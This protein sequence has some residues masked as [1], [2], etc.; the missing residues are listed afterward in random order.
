MSEPSPFLAVSPQPS[1]PAE[2][3]GPMQQLGAELRGALRQLRAAP[4]A[5][6]AGL[7]LELRERL[8]AARAALI[9]GRSRIPAALRHYA[10]SLTEVQWL[11]DAWIAGSEAGSEDEALLQRDFF[12]AASRLFDDEPEAFED[13]PARSQGWLGWWAALWRRIGGRG[14]EGRETVGPAL[15]GSLAADCRPRKSAG[16]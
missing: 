16:S 12:H 10:V 3:S 11:L 8:E 2:L 13:R 6:A 14:A 4:Q 15:P 5:S 9:G 7:R 1:V